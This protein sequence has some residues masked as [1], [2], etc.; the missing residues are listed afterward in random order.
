MSDNK[1]L[2]K[3]KD[4][5]FDEFYTLYED[6]EEELKHYSDQFK[7]KVIYCNCDDILTSN[8]W[9]YF[10][11]NFTDLGIKKLYGSY[12]TTYPAHPP[13]ELYE[14]REDAGYMEYVTDYIHSDDASEYA[15]RWKRFKSVDT[16]K[17][18][19]CRSEECKKLMQKSDIVVTNPP[20][21]IFREYFNM[22]LESGKKFLIL[23]NINA[24][25][26]IDVF[27]ALMK[28]KIRVGYSWKSAQYLT[29]EEYTGS[30]KM[31]GD[32]RYTQIQTMWLTNLEVKDKPFYYSGKRYIADNYKIYDN[33]DALNVDTLADIPD[34]Y[35]GLMGVP[36]TIF[37][38]LNP[39]Q[40]EVKGINRKGYYEPTK[41]YINPKE[42][43]K[44]VEF[45]C[46]K[47]NSDF[48]LLTDKKPK[49][50]YYTADNV[51]GYL[52]RVYTRVLIQRKPLKEVNK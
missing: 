20:F 16:G 14:Y 47:V 44:K 3:A 37:K 32:E 46:A 29:T 38:V 52:E 24:I 5:R 10:H 13:T 40:F 27:E 22:L 7:D 45:S 43:K 48:T 50:T 2:Q 1:N 8:F 25:T 18:G 33:C 30:V 34:D 21:S 42:H 39:D 31:I 23:A 11:Y 17:Y 4:L 41:T 36:I 6:V 28:N 49:G 19:D 15:C 12:Y 26:Y 51:D 9:R 35:N